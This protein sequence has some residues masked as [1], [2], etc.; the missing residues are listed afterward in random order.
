[1]AAPARPGRA[2]PSLDELQ[3]AA[4]VERHVEVGAHQDAQP[5]DREVI[6]RLHHHEISSYGVSPP[7]GDDGDGTMGMVE[8][9]V[10]DRADAGARAGRMV[11]PAKHHEIGPA[12]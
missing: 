9:R 11:V 8:D 10:L 1:M 12:E 2:G 6:D 3:A 4:A 7:D 5:R